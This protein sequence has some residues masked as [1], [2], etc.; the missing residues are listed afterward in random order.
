MAALPLIVLQ[1]D[2]FV[3][4]EEGARKLMSITNDVAVISIAGLY[5]SGKS[6]LLNR[7]LGKQHG[8]AVGPTVNPCTKGIFVW[9]EPIHLEELNMSVILID[10][11]GIGSIQQDKNYDTKIFRYT[12]S[13]D[14]STSVYF[15]FFLC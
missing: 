13:K 1:G 9:G 11:E 6:Y 4:H 12:I 3:V 14:F 2:K 5:R 7:L 10:T 15:N 8:F